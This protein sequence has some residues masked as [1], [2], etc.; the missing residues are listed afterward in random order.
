ML[1]A[2][3]PSEEH[4]SWHIKISTGCSVARCLAWEP[5]R[6]SLIGVTKQYCA[7]LF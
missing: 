5:N 7:E 6:A 2:I 3:K 1:C 4:M